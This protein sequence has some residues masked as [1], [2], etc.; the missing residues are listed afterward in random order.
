MALLDLVLPTACGGCGRHGGLLCATCRGQ[1]R[2]ASDDEDLFITSLPG[3]VIGEAL[4]LGMAAFLYEGPVQR[5]LHRLKYIGASRLAPVLADATLPTLDRLLRLSGP[6]PLLAVPV[7]AERLRSRGYNQAAL[8]ADR[9]AT[10]RRLP[11]TDVLVR[12]RQT[13]K[14][15]RLDRAARLRNLREAFAMRPGIAVPPV[16]IVVDDILTTSATLEACAG[17][18]RAAGSA[19]V[20]GFAVAREA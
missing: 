3:I 10:R 19:E 20:Y 6:A 4:T 15:H 14:Q 2:P 18:L 13:G 1:L 12:V 9:L 16:V 17:A 5:A 11:R 7:H 8:I